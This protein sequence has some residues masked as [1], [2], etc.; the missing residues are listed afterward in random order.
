MADREANGASELGVSAATVRRRN[1]NR[2]SRIFPEA[3]PRRQNI[4]NAPAQII[5]LPRYF[6]IRPGS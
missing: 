4:I 5:R 1:P 2:G 6:S 3:R